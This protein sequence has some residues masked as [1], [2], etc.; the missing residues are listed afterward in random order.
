MT[1]N[2]PTHED[3]IRRCMELARQAAQAGNSPFGSLIVRDGQVV[4]ESHNQVQTLLD[5]SAHGEIAAIRVACQALGT[6]DLSGATLYTSAEPCY[7]CS[8]A[9]RAARLSRVVIGARSP[10]SGGVTSI[11]P[12]LLDPNVILWAPPPEVV[13]GVLQGECEALLRE[14]GLDFI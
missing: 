4:G 7:M 2:T 6:M 14:F 9:I 12:I 13:E 11:H 3:Y 10:N 1:Q 8:Y 5:I